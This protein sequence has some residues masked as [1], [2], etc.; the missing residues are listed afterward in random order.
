MVGATEWIVLAALMVLAESLVVAEADVVPAAEWSRR[1]ETKLRPRRS[2]SEPRALSVDG[3]LGL[4]EGCGAGRITSVLSLL[5][6]C[7]GRGEASNWRFSA[8]LDGRV[9]GEG[10]GCPIP[11]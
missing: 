4:G 8:E 10:G 7:G 11:G 1:W 6:A 9:G 3:L 2:S 5:R